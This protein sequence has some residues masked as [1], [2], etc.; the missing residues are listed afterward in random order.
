[1]GAVM[2]SFQ[3]AAGQGAAGAPKRETREGG[4]EVTN[5]SEATINPTSAFVHFPPQQGIPPEEK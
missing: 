2:C 4:E 5:T 3:K 1:M